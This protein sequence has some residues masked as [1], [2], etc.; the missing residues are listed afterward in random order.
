MLGQRF[1]NT[2]QE[3]ED[4]CIDVPNDQFSFLELVI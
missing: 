3:L 2:V 4:L 1:Y